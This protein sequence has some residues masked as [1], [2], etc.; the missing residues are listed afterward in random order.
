MAKKNNWG[1]CALNH[2]IIVDLAKTNKLLDISKELNINVSTLRG[3][4]NTNGIKFK[5]G[6]EPPEGYIETLVKLYEG[7]VSVKIIADEL[8]C[9][10]TTVKTYLNKL[11]P[12]IGIQDHLKEV[13]VQM[14]MSGID[15]DY[16]SN[17]FSLRRKD[18]STF[19]KENDIDFYETINM[20][21][22]DTMFYV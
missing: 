4:C 5:G 12:T 16:I 20:D 6:H 2:E 8:G 15:I 3:Y 17:K 9:S 7:G 18:V 10:D 1:A 13:V 22:N 19:L 14:V 11:Y 21:H